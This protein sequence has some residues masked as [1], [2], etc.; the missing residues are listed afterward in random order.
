VPSFFTQSYHGYVD[1]I[2]FPY[3]LWN[4]HW[5]V[6]FIDLANNQWC[7]YYSRPL[8][9]R[10]RSAWENA[11]ALALTF[12]V[13]FRQFFLG[14]EPLEY[15]VSDCALQDDTDC[16]GI[17]ACLNIVDLMNNEFPRVDPLSPEV[18]AGFRDQVRKLLFRKMLAGFG[19]DPADVIL[20]P[21]EG[22]SDPESNDGG[23][24]Y[25]NMVKYL[26]VMNSEEVIEEFPES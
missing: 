2:I 10:G 7:F 24:E 8:I 23:S 12:F 20:P 16:C 19:F 26:A 22:R 18:I 11:E 25:S 5:A 13:D 21:I 6:L 9:V 15:A 1:G 3:N 14:E 17:H 4:I